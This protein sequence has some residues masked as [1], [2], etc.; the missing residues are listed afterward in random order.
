MA[1]GIVY[2][3]TKDGKVP[4]EDFLDGCPAKVEARF[5]AVLEAVRDAPP[6]Q[7][8]GILD[9]GSPKELRER[10]FDGPQ[11]AAITGMVKDSGKKFSDR[12]YARVRKLG[13]EYLA[14]LPR[15]IAT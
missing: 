5:A 8:S 12:D 10:G 9:N 3:A 15:H 1:W 11:I 7:F 4:A 2:Y 6:P 13:R 14:E